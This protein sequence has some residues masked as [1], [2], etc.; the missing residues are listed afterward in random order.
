[1]NVLEF[2]MKLSD[3]QEI[4]GTSF[5]ET[6]LRMAEKIKEEK[7]EKPKTYTYKVWTEECKKDKEENMIYLKLYHGGGVG[8]AVMIGVCDKSGELVE[9]GS[10]AGFS[11]RGELICCVGV[12][13]KFCAVDEHG[14]IK[15]K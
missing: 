1:M 7:K 11:M 14:S 9:D 12:S 4:E 6:V 13:D 10:I 5:E 15:V 2:I 8:N 3:A